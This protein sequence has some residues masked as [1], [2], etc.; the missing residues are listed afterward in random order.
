MKAILYK[1]NYRDK[2]G[3]PCEQIGD[4]E[5]IIFDGRKIK[6]DQIEGIKK[7]TKNKIR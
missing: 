7:L 2:Q 3:Y 5:Y 1:V 6:A 4:L